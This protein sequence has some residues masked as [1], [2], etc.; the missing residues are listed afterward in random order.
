[1][2]R[3]FEIRN[4]NLEQETDTLRNL[5]IDGTL[6]INGSLELPP[7]VDATGPTGPDGPI[8]TIDHVVSSILDLQSLSP[9]EGD[10]ALVTSN[11]ED[12]DNSKLYLYDGN[13]WSFISDFSGI[14]GNT[15]PAGVIGID[16]VTGP[17]GLTGATGPTWNSSVLTVDA[18]NIGVNTSNPAYD[19]DVVGN[20]NLTGA[21]KLN[22]VDMVLNDLGDT[23]TVTTSP[24][25]GD[26]LAWDGS[27]WS[28]SQFCQAI[29]RGE[30]WNGTDQTFTVSPNATLNLGKDI[31]FGT[32]TD[33]A[34]LPLSS[35]NWDTYIGRNDTE[36]LWENKLGRDAIFHIMIDGHLGGTGG[37][38]D[39]T[40]TEVWCNIATS[41]ADIKSKG[42][43]DSTQKIVKQSGGL[44]YAS[45][46]HCTFNMY[47]PAGAS[48]GIVLKTTSGSTTTY[49]VFPIIHVTLL[50]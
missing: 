31:K 14:Q 43:D 41:D 16:G 44:H 36:G 26:L 3:K 9:S 48:I 50:G 29:F 17:Q 22:G 45:D 1:M 7:G 28:T 5:T 46:I 13:I 47:V 21:I 49:N 10:F 24:L 20:I 37:N 35:P 27:N 42:N 6:T 32:Q 39:I 23:D 11:P 19:V 4:T 33:N 8:F 2:S 40:Q 25:D 38:S 30:P 34:T 18:P 15:G 12:A